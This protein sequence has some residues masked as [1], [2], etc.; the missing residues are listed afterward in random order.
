M[1]YLNLEPDAAEW[2]DKRSGVVVMAERLPYALIC[3]Q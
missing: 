3:S 2:L 1:K